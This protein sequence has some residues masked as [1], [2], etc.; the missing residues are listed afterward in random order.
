MWTRLITLR[1]LGLS[2]LL[3]LSYPSGYA[4]AWTASEWIGIVESALGVEVTTEKVAPNVS[5]VCENCNGTGK[6]GDGVVSVKC[7]AC[8][9][10]GKKKKESKKETSAANPV[11][12]F[13]CSKFG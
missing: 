3:S 7:A 12:P 13:R 11:E 1:L 9:G 2:L 8:D 6:V 10:T 5:D 4:E